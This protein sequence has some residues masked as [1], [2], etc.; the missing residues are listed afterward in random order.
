MSNVTPGNSNVIGSPVDL[1]SKLVVERSKKVKSVEQVFYDL[2]Q[3]LTIKDP[4]VHLRGLYLKI[5]D[6]NFVVR[7]DGAIQLI[8][9]DLFSKKIK[10]SP[11]T[12]GFAT[13][14]FKAV[15]AKDGDY[16]YEKYSNHPHFSHCFRFLIGDV[17]V[18]HFRSYASLHAL[19]LAFAVSLTSRLMSIPIVHAAR[20]RGGGFSQRIQFPMTLLFL[21]YAKYISQCPNEKSM[22][23]L[24]KLSLCTDFS[25]A[26]DQDL[27]PGYEG[28]FPL[29]PKHMRDVL[30]KSFGS[31][32][33]KIQFYF[34][35]LQSK[36]LCK[37]VSDD[38]VQEALEKHRDTLASPEVRTLEPEFAAELVRQGEKLGL[39]LRDNYNPF[40]T[41]K[42]TGSASFDTSRKK[43][44][45]LGEIYSRQMAS[46]SRGYE[47][48]SE[49]RMEPVVI[50][51]FGPPACG[52]TTMI[53]EILSKVHRDLFPEWNLRDLSYSRSCSTDH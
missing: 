44:G 17:L 51:L 21:H 30:N 13:R 32:Q 19:Y 41:S 28:A 31:R 4:D 40:K 49:N 36:S 46:V 38:M 15:K 25:R 33:E 27:P 11:L 37:E 3:R 35:V 43:G 42:A 47:Q 39:Y 2:T 18:S 45:V 16:L 20:N 8:N 52:K 14:A 10:G 9:F 24:I 29:F 26:S 53:R 6:G 22:V 34:S 50:G 7:S 5:C 48:D 23:K 1:K 12:K